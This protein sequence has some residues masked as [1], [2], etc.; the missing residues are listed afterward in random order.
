MHDSSVLDGL[1]ELT[2]VQVL[3][4]GDYYDGPLDGLALYDGREYWFIAVAD[5]HG[6]PEDQRWRRY[7]LH[8]ISD[9]QVQAEWVEHREFVA[10]V[11]GPGCMH[12]PACARG[13]GNA[14]AAADWYRAHPWDMRPDHAS[15]PAFGW[16][17]G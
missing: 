5:E 7:V 3:W 6:N 10:V 17:R 14:D 12:K 13:P 11:G 15:A 8:A 2:G 16:F 9:E 4:F 1:A